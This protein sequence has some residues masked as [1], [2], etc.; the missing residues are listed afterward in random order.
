MNS[1]RKTRKASTQDKLGS[2]FILIESV[3][4][5]RS[6][7]L[8]AVE[9]L[10]FLKQNSMTVG[11]FHALIHKTVKRCK[12]PNTETEERTIRDTLYLGM[13]SQKVRYKCINFI[14]DGEELTIDFI[15]KHLE[16][17]DSNSHHKSLSQMDSIV[18][19]SFMSCDHRKNKGKRK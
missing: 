18:G 6:N 15:M 3:L 14:N 4:A 13:K 9:D 11:E 2:Y 5:P 12:F 1:P 7:P 8:L 19:V 16:V 10:Y 17:E